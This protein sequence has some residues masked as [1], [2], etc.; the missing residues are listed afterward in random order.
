MTHVLTIHFAE[1]AETIAVHVLNVGEMFPPA[2]WEPGTH[3][4]FGGSRHPL[5]AGRDFASGKKQPK[6]TGSI[7]TRSFRAA[8]GTLSDTE[9]ALDDPNFWGWISRLI[10]APPDGVTV[11]LPTTPAAAPEAPDAG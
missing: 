2:P 8:S 9:L 7:V 1:P 4:G 3:G 11:E 6:P 10:A 5:I